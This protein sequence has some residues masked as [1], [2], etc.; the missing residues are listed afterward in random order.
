MGA[1][2]R[3]ETVTTPGNAELK[4]FLADNEPLTT[5]MSEKYRD[6]SLD[7]GLKKGGRFYFYSGGGNAAVYHGPGGFLYPAG[8]HPV[9]PDPQ[10]LRHHLGGLVRLYSIMGRSD[11][12]VGMTG[13]FAQQPKID[14]EYLLLSRRASTPPEVPPPPHP[15]LKVVTPSPS[16]WK[17][18]LPL[19]IA[20]EVEEVLLPGRSANPNVSKSTLTESLEMQRVLVAYYRGQAVGRVATNARGYRTEQV[21]G[22]YTD[23]AWRRRGLARWLMAH[24]LAGI[25]AEGKTASLF[26]KPHNVA[27]LRLYKGLGFLFESHFRISYYV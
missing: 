17:H 14:I 18:L 4:R 10:V 24:L 11:D 3:W 19:Q 2:G 27:A 6:H 5:V 12:V 22:V 8:I 1:L 25:T 15:D 16:E 9:V 7:R 26:V 23:P 20:Y 21:G 13:L